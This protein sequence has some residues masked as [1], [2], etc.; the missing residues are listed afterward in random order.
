MI[1]I[2]SVCSHAAMV[3]R[4]GEC[5]NRF[6]INWLGLYVLDGLEKH[7][8]MIADNVQAVAVLPKQ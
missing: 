1:I 2:A 6:L 4:V 3:Y 5:V 7:I 8:E